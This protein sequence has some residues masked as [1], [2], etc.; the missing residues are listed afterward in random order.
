MNKHYEKK[1]ITDRN[2]PKRDAQILINKLTRLSSHVVGVIYNLSVCTFLFFF[3]VT[4]R[5]DISS[6]HA[7]NVN[8]DN[9]PPDALD[10]FCV[11]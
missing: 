8:Q 1:H 11:E 2:E 6:T 10:L 3:F 9:K 7:S 5:R 4:N